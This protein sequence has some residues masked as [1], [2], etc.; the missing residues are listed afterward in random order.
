MR[1]C[2]VFVCVDVLSSVFL[3]LV[4]SERMALVRG[5]SVLYAT[6]QHDQM[7]IKVSCKESGADLYRVTTTSRLLLFICVV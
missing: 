6:R 2:L 1:I 3:V 7:A 4:T 5:S